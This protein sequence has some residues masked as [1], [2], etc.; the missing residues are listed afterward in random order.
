[1]GPQYDFDDVDGFTTGAVGRP[2][3]RTFFI[4]ARAEGTCIT[5]KCEKQQVA[6]LAEYLRGLLHDLPPAGDQPLADAMELVLPADPDFVLGPIGLGFDREH[7]RFVV[8][9]E[10]LVPTSDEDD[11]EEDDDDELD[12]AR[13]R[14]FLSRGQAQAFCD[15]AERIVAA[16]RPSCRFCGN[17]IDPDGHPCPR[18]N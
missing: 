11:E 2:G 3:A 12:R 5:V 1:M 8:Q 17:P 18:M 14:A 10:E 4:Q 9:L 13:L 16:G 7:D 6:A 15:H